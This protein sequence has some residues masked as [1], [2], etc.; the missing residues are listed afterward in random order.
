MKLALIIG[1]VVLMLVAGYK[2]QAW[3]ASAVAAQRAVAN[4]VLTEALGQ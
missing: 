1:A 2:L 4:Q 3:A